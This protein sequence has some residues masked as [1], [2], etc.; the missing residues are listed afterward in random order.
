MF[1]NGVAM[2]PEARARKSKYR[3]S[4]LDYVTSDTAKLEGDLGPSD[5]RKL[6]EY[7]TAIREVETVE[8]DTGRASAYAERHSIY[9]SLYPALQPFY[10]SVA[11]M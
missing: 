6:D 8:P 7:F 10:R 5:R 11:T 4:I 1:G 9:Q 3:R 2:S